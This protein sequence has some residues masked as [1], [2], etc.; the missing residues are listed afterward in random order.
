MLG[1]KCRRLTLIGEPG[2]DPGCVQFLRGDS[3]T[4]SSG[5]YCLLVSSSQSFLNSLLSSSPYPALLPESVY[6]I[7]ARGRGV[8]KKVRAVTG[9]TAV[10]LPNLTASKF[11]RIFLTPF[12]H[13]DSSEN[14][15]KRE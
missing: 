3:D 14:Q 4:A 15:I 11:N 5:G 7:S 1:Y 9:S 2:V 13:T 12:S 8:D 10:L 6:L